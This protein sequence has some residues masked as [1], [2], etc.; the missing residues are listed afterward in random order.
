MLRTLEIYN[1]QWP[2]HG[3]R[4][5]E[6]QIENCKMKIA[7]RQLKSWVLPRISSLPFR[8]AAM[9]FLVLASGIAAQAQAKR[10]VV[11]KVDG[12]PY[13][14]VDRFARETDPETGKSRLPWFDHIFY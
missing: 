6:L 13:E 11:I 10:V 7:N 1:L 12:L 14:M 5:H 4:K 8:F 9:I 2:R 3:K